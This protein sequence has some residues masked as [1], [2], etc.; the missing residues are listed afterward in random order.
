MHILHFHLSLSVTPIGF[1]WAV[2]STASY[3][4]WDSSQ[5]NN[6]KAASKVEVSWMEFIA[7]N[8]QHTKYHVLVLPLVFR[9][10]PFGACLPDFICGP[11]FSQRMIANKIYFKAYP[12]FTSSLNFILRV[13]MANGPFRHCIWFR[14]GKEK[15]KVIIIFCSISVVGKSAWNVNESQKNKKIR[16]FKFQID[17]KLPNTHCW[18]LQILD[19]VIEIDSLWSYSFISS[20]EWFPFDFCYRLLTLH[21]HFCEELSI[22][23]GIRTI[24]TCLFWM[25]RHETSS[26][27]SSINN[28]RKYVVH[29][30]GSLVSW[31][32]KSISTSIL[33]GKSFLE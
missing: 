25:H 15:D 5:S 6:I 27:D 4:Q 2:C 26:R 30:L 13:F 21:F 16:T 20:I 17:Q 7:C 14:W 24:G 23:M 9:Q 1:D 31:V 3:I 29:H 8:I 32:K 11:I 19:V 33:N 12:E 18:R 22:V 10:F 28:W